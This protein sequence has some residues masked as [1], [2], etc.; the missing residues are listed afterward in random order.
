MGGRASALVVPPLVA[1]GAGVA[2]GVY[3]F[4]EPLR[5]QAAARAAAEGGGGAE[6]EAEAKAKAE[7]GT[8]GREKT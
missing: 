8:V 2:S 1:A 5:D 3:L 7:A 4:A 6:A